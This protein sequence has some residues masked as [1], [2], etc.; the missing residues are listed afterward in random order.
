VASRRLE[1]R[2]RSSR[3]RDSRRLRLLALGAIVPVLLA[4]ILLRAATERLPP[5]TL[6]RTLA[7]SLTLGG[8]HPTLAWPREGEAAVEIEG[9][10]SFGASGANVPVPIAS[11]AKLMTAYLTLRT[12]PLSAGQDGFTI[13]VTPAQAAEEQ[14]RAAEGQSVV[15]VRAGE[16]LSERK[17]LQA[18]MLPSANN[19]AAMLA[20]YDAGSIEA[21]V[22]KMNAQA[23]ALG[24]RS[25]TYTDPSGF[26]DTTVSTA[27]DQLELAQAAMRVPTLAAI[28]DMPAARL[29]LAGVVGNYNQLVGHDGY[30]GIKTGSDRNAGGCLVFAKRLAVDGRRVTVLGVVLGQREGPLIEA[31]LSSAQRLGDSA[32]SAV[33]VQS[34]LPQGARVAV[35]RSTDG[36]HASV[37]AARA[38]QTLGWPGLRVPVEVSFGPLAS[39]LHHNQR[40]G[41]L[42]VGRADAARSSTAAVAK[43]SIGRPSL[44]WRLAHLL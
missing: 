21:F 15:P 16:R 3:E 33:R 12:H 35:L 42:T 24:M 8:H 9:L 41:T 20:A 1:A 26:M 19:V 5:P 22:A 7:A 40:L 11:V 32:A 10:G 6:H 23:R 13:T 30:V 44:G 31:A 17:A 39:R 38:V 14:R 2:R 36:A 27:A 37:V 18:L 34:A 29:P 25:T 28:V 43:S 4:A